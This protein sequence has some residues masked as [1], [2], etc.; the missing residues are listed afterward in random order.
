MN[1]WWIL[2]CAGLA[3]Q[4][5]GSTVSDPDFS[6]YRGFEFGSSVA[7]VATMAK[8]APSEARTLHRRPA[9]LQDLDWTP[10]SNDSVAQVVFSFYNDQL[11]R[12]VADYA[13]D[14]TEG[15]T[16]AELIE[17]I[18]DDYGSPAVRTAN[19]RTA[20][21]VEAMSGTPLARW[22]DGGHT[23]VLY[24]TSTYPAGFRL[25]ATAVA[26]DGRAR[27]AEAEA[28]RLDARP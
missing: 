22:E 24:R 4:I 21:R 7:A 17:A 23:V 5:L 16:A 19:T 26:L 3:A 10:S 15:M 27:Q 28:L 1:V 11:F 8:T 14:R 12:V 2:A 13:S 20:S 6:R 25:I 18:S 9:L